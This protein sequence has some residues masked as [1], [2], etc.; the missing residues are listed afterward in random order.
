MHIYI[1]ADKVINL[2]KDANVFM[3]FGKLFHPLQLIIYFR[4]NI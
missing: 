3:S 1:I 2:I 4:N